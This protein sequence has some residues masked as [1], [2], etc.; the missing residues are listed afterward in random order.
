MKTITLDDEAYQRLKAWKRSKGDSFSKVVKR[1][2]P[3]AGSMA[4]FLKFAEKEQTDRLPG[5]E[6]LEETIVERPSA[7]PDPWS[8]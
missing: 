1:V 6:I 7:N 3:E 4:S 5:N 2:V 8:S